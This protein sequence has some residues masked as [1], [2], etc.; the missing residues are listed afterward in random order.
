MQQVI[1]LSSNA[2]MHCQPA[3]YKG[4]TKE[5]VYVWAENDALRAIPFDRASN[6]LNTNAEIVFNNVL[7]RPEAA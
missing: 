2:N 3:Y 5:F 1:Q 6:L 7:N 4:N